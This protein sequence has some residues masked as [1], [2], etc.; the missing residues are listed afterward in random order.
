V[1]GRDE[2][3]GY[4]L[5]GNAALF[6]G[7]LKLVK[8]LAPLG[9]GQWRLFDIEADP[10]ETRDLQKEKPLE[11]AAMQKDYQAWADAQGVLPVP[12]DY[13]PVM[14]VTINTVMDYWLPHFGPWIAAGL[15]LPI[16]AWLAWRRRK[17]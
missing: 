6:K 9:D 2:I 5:S 13:N 7:P 1:R 3:L 12:A 8:N 15:F 4:E 14:Q 16:A 10:G 11:F 17:A